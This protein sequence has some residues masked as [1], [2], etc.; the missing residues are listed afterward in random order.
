MRK[1][2][3]N[4][5]DLNNDILKIGILFIVFVIIGTYLNKIW[6]QYQ[7]IGIDSINKLKESYSS[8]IP[9]TDIILINLKSDILLML[10]ILIFNLFVITFPISICIALI[11]GMS[12]GYIINSTIIGFGLNGISIV[13]LSIIKN[14]IMIIGIV[15]LLIVSK[16]YIGTILKNHKKLDKEQILFLSSRYI[17][18]ALI[19]S[20]IT[21]IIQAILN[22]A[23]IWIVKFFIK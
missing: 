22:S 16:E 1:I 21:V 14:S 3:K 20:C 17:I 7:D 10:G 9:L 13:L 2:N 15:V 6:P 18:N 4:H 19:I 5:N 23:F 11:K 12:I 8:N